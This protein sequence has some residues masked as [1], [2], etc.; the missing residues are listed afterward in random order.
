MEV[1]E[2]VSR[3]GHKVG[4]LPAWAWAAIPAVGYIAYSY[5]RAAK[6]DNA[7]TVDQANPTAD[8]T[9]PN[10]DYGLNTGGAYL[11][12]YG[13]V[14]YGSSNPPIDPL[15]T[16]PTVT[17][18][19][20]GRMAMNWLISQ[21]ITSSDALTA[22]NSYLYGNPQTVNSTQLDALQS[23]LMHYGPAPQP[24][25]VP[26]ITPP[27][28]K[29]TPGP[30]TNAVARPTGVTS[31]SATWGPPANDGGQPI[32]GYHI[33]GYVGGTK[34]GT[35]FVLASANSVEMAG[36]PGDTDVA[37]HI[38]AQNAV[39]DGTD[40]VATTH[41]LKSPP[42]AIPPAA[43]PPAPGTYVSSPTSHLFTKTS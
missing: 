6:S 14:P 8:P 13:S 17:N 30:V 32:L 38:M 34:I 29:T 12:G 41:T 24:A 43:P 40:F 36:F 23:V 19:T 18:E 10:A 39:G 22:V 7:A 11:P 5:Y 26:S 16:T 15:T 20:W 31:V 2:T 3:M 37:I 42:P 25:F 9:D 21:G 4:P 28:A 27:P 33:D 35:K 1:P